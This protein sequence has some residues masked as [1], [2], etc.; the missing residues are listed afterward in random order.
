MASNAVT[1]AN[2]PRSGMVAASWT[3]NS[4]LARPRSA[5]AA[6]ALAIGQPTVPLRPEHRELLQAA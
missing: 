1:S 6:R 2:L 5:A 3:A 4:T